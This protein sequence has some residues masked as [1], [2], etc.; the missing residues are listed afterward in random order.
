MMQLMIL[1]QLRILLLY[2]GIIGTSAEMKAPMQRSKSR[3]CHNYQIPINIVH[4]KSYQCHLLL[5]VL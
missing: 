2:W 5:P 3:H 4:I 1:V